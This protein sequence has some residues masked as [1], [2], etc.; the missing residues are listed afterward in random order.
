MAARV[1]SLATIRAA[2]LRN[3]Q[4]FRAKPASHPAPIGGWNAR[5]SLAAMDVADAVTLDNWWPNPS[6]VQAR[7]GYTQHETGLP[8]LTQ[9]LM[10]YGGSTSQKMFAASGISF[11]DVTTGGAVG[12]PSVTGLSN[13]KWEFVNISTA[14]GHFMECVNGADKLRGFDGTTWWTDGDGSHDITGVDTSTCINVNLF[15]NRLWLIEGN[16]LRAWYLPTSSIAGAARSLDFSSIARLGGSLVAMGTWTIDAGYGVDD[17]AV[18]VTNQGEIIVY[19]GID[20]DFAATWALAGVWEV[21]SAFSRRCLMKWGG[22]LLILT[23]DGLFPLAQYL[24]SSRLDPRVALSDKISSAISAATASYG[25][26]FGWCMEYF[27]KADML[28][29]NVPV[30]ADTG[31]IQ[32]CMN[33]ITKAWCSF[34]GINAACWGLLSDN[35]YFGGSNFIGRMWNGFSDYPTATPVN[36]NTNALTA[37]SDFGDAGTLK[38]WMMVRPIFLTNGSPATL[39]GMNIDFDQSDNTGTLSFSP[40]SYATWDTAVWDTAVWGGGLGVSKNWQSVNGIGTW[41]AIRVKT[42]TQ[43][44]ETNWISTSYTMEKGA[45]I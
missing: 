33:T 4:G 5:D 39:G 35:L 18:F 23:Y 42:A 19:R 10:T 43:G 14:G 26:N 3:K 36:I 11:Y 28:I 1:Q 34:S 12:A 45:I 22:D 29:V 41:A 25:S 13:A 6:Q 16:S 30:N 7:M 17:L 15:K 31:Q 8:S 32:Y 2:R 44:I 27:A 20:P 40:T 9:S 37:F 21:G 38:R 24:Q